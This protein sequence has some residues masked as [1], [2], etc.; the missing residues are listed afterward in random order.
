MGVFDDRHAAA[1]DTIYAEKNYAAEC[2]AVVKLIERFGDG[3]I[4]TLLD[5]GCGTGKHA[6]IFAQRGLSVTGV[7]LSAP[8]LALARGRAGQAGLESN[9]EFLS[10][11]IRSYSSARRFDAALMNFNVLGYMTSNDDALNAFAAARGN[12]R[13]G[14]LMIA[15]FWY[16]PAIV[17]DP[18]GQNTRTFGSE[19]E[20]MI[21]TSSG[22]QLP[23]EQCCEIKLE[24]T[25]LRNGEVVDGSSEIHRVRYFFPLEL[26]LLLRING[27]RLLAL[28][29]FPEIDTAARAQKWVAAMVAKAI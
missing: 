23:D 1:Y 17:A 7:D 29:G 13:D 5:L 22:R 24:I 2:D 12:L 3:R 27:F 15:D 6:T 4:Q 21:R 8:M 16:G 25:R 11:D 19:R 10:G 9:T 14:G 20:A 26:E 28:T 18:P